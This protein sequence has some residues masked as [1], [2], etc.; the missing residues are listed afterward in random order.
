MGSSSNI[1]RSSSSRHAHHTSPTAMMMM[2]LRRRR[3]RRILSLIMSL[4]LLLFSIVISFQNTATNIGVVEAVVVEGAGTAVASSENENEIENEIESE[5]LSTGSCATSSSAD[6]DKNETVCITGSKRLNSNE[7]YKE[8]NEDEDEDKEED[9]DEMKENRQC[10]FDA[11]NGLCDRFPKDMFQRCPYSC[12]NYNAKLGSTIYLENE[13][14]DDIYDENDDNDNEIDVCENLIEDEICEEYAHYNELNCLRNQSYMWK[15][16][17][18]SCLKCFEFIDYSSIEINIGVTQI[19]IDDS[20]M[21]ETNDE[22]RPTTSSKD[23]G[24][25]TKFLSTIEKTN[26][27]MVQQ[28]M[29]EDKYIPVRKYC[30]NYNNLCTF[31]VTTRTQEVFCNQDNNNGIN[32]KLVCGPACHSCDEMLLSQKEM[33]ILYDCTPDT[34]TNIFINDNDNEEE[35]EEDEDEDED[36]EEDEDEV[37]AEDEDNKNNEQKQ[38]KKIT[39]DTM[40]Q[41]IIGEVPYPKEYAN[42]VP[43]FNA[44]V[45]SRPKLNPIIHQNMS[46]NALLKKDFDFV[47]GGPWI[48]QLDN[49]L[50]NEECT[51]L[52]ELGDIIGRDISTI[53]VD[54]DESSSEESTNDKDEDN[55]DSDNDNDSESDSES[56]DD[57]EEEEE[58]NEQWRT[59]TTA[60]CDDDDCNDDPV[61]KRVQ[62]K[63]GVT[64]SVLDPAYFEHLQLL[65]YIPGQFYKNHHDE[66]GSQHDIDYN[67][68][69]PRILTFFLYLND[70]DDDDDDDDDDSASAGGETRFTNIF[71]DETNIYLDVKPKKGRALIWPSM[72]N[73]DLYE[74]EPKTYHEAR[75][76]NKGNKYGANAW[77]HLRDVRNLHC[78]EDQLEPIRSKLDQIQQQ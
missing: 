47:L 42:K 40:F 21:M 18:K 61:T 71:G 6:N 20:M 7:I 25:I 59:S 31:G 35:D 54:D 36:E 39:L 4:L 11:K 5:S 50:T 26:D 51:R 22:Y 67:S 74:F 65:K 41:R 78:D 58:E 33:D 72:L 9:E 63:I 32:N 60:W 3:Q 76:V 49:F 19:I 77:L 13:N 12:I 75:I 37:N 55:N 70:L 28:V 64:T 23:G 8:E 38:Q 69:G 73:E 34:S 57:D 10:I 15:H 53:E 17:P 52:I 1:S 44:T 29:K 27:Y 16:C 2:S 66:S 43:L 14:D 48:I 45:L 68:S 56:E 30:H 24:I 62:E 46:V